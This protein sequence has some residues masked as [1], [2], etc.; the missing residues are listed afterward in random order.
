VL[1]PNALKVAVLGAMATLAG[2]CGS[3][4]AKAAWSGAEQ[5][6]S[7][8]SQRNVNASLLDDG[9]SQLGFTATTAPGGAG[10]YVLSRAPKATAWTPTFLGTGPPN[11]SFAFGRDGSAA[12]VFEG[13]PGGRQRHGLGHLP[14]S[15]RQLGG[16]DQARGRAAHRRRAGG[17]D[18]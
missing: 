9:T 15:R 3:D 1:R 16:G 13:R 10:M 7:Y 18:R 2:L 17:G 14:Q 6:K 5:V 8:L 12:V 11:A 4:P